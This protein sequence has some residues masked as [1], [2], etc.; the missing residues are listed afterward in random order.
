TGKKERK[1]SLLK[2]RRGLFL[3][4]RYSDKMS[5]VRRA[6]VV[7]EEET[8]MVHGAF[9]ARPIRV[10]KKAD[11]RYVSMSIICRGGRVK[12]CR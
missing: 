4:T 8:V 2:E 12:T 7:I 10:T 1:K 11:T 5:T 3:K 9:D 6:K